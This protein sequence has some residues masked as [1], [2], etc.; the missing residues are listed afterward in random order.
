M[1]PA[2][3]PQRIRTA[4]LTLPLGR[5]KQNEKGKRKRK[6]KKKETETEEGK[7]LL[8]RNSGLRLRRLPPPSDEET[9]KLREVERYGKLLLILLLLK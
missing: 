6:K 4:N 5:N 8:T 2:V 1:Q 3:V 9:E 7:T